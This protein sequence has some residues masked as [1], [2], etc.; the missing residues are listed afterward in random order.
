M[1]YDYIHSQNNTMHTFS[2]SF[3]WSLNYS[4]Q[5]SQYHCCGK[6]SG[7][8]VLNIR[9]QNETKTNNKPLKRAD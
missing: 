7:K 6:L 3:S 9:D 2:G 8:N 1:K 5:C 4:L